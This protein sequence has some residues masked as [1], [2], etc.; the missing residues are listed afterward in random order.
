MLQ[1]SRCGSTVQWSCLAGMKR[2]RCYSTQSTLQCSPYWVPLRKL[3]G[4]ISYGCL[5]CNRYIV[6]QLGLL[7]PLIQVSRTVVGEVSA[8][9]DCEC[10]L[11]FQVQR[12]GTEKLREAFAEDPALRAQLNAPYAASPKSNRT[13]S[14]EKRPVRSEGESYELSEKS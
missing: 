8:P 4:A 12:I 14:D 11:T 10:K 9:T 3:Y 6:L 7:G 1:G 2:W 13:V 5:S